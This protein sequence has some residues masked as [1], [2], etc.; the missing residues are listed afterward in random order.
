[1]KL[2]VYSKDFILNKNLTDI[3]DLYVNIKYPNKRFCYCGS[4]VERTLG[5]GEVVSPILTSSTILQFL[6]FLVVYQ[7]V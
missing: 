1:M 6:M 3:L 7:M 2:I 4:V 5:K